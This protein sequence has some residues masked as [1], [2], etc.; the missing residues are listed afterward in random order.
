M[1]KR[2]F[3]HNLT[4]NTKQKKTCIRKLLCHPTSERI[5]P[6]LHTGRSKWIN[7]SLTD[8]WLETDAGAA[9]RL[10]PVQ[11]VDVDAVGEMTALTDWLDLWPASPAVTFVPA[12]L[13]SSGEMLLSKKIQYSLFSQ[14]NILWSIYLLGKLQTDMHSARKFL[15]TIMLSLYYRDQCIKGFLNGMCNALYKSM[16]YFLVTY[17]MPVNTEQKQGSQRALNSGLNLRC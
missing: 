14:K 13:Y 11:Y 4:S 5:G 10:V 8:R 12:Y 16:F 1:K 9:V 15:K 2:R 7:W 3:A 17:S 6:I